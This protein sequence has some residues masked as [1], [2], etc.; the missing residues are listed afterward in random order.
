M[1][2]LVVIV[3]GAFV[4]ILRERSTL[5]DAWQGIATWLTVQSWDR[6]HVCTRPG[7]RR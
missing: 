5:R 6:D 7:S 4:V 3:N 1:S 2:V